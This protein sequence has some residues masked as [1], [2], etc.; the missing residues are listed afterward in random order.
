MSIGQLSFLE[1]IGMKDLKDDELPKTYKGIYAMHKYWSKKPYNLVADYIERFSSPGDI[2]LD[3]FCGSGVT[4]VESVR[5]GRRAIGIDINPVAIFI[6]RMGLSHIDIRDLRYTFA[7]LKM[8]MQPIIDQLY[9]TECLN[10]RNP[11]AIVTHTIWEE[12]NPKEVWYRCP[13]CRTRKAIK[14]A[15]QKD[16]KAAL[17]PTNT[18]QWAP[19]TQLVENSRVNVKAGMHVSDLFTKRALVG[20]SLLL[21]RIEQVQ[22]Q[23]IKS[24]L[25]FCFT[26]ALPQASNMVFVIRRR[27]KQGGEQKAGKAEVGS[28]VIGY[29]VPSEHFEINV[30][31]CFE[32]RFKRILRGKRE[33]NQV[34]P[35][36]A[37]QCSNFEQLDQVEQGYWIKTGT[38]TSL[39]IPS[40]TVGYVF[41][42]PPHGNR[43]PYL[44]LSLMWNSWLRFESNWE[45]EIVISAS[46]ERQKDE[47]DYRKRLAAAFG[48]IWRVLG[49]NRYASIVFNSLSDD[50]WLS[51]L[52]S[53]L[54]TGFEIVDIQPLDYS[55]HSVIQDTRKQAL[56]TDLVITCQKQIP[57]QARRIRFNGSELELERKLSDYLVHHPEGAETYQILN[58]LLVSSIPT[59]SIYR[60]SSILDTLE[61]KFKFA[62]GRW[63]LESKG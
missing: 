17:E 4:V 60:V 54:G 8:E 49:D 23:E 59:G 32:N 63:C 51:L 2:V 13:R 47:E 14:E 30:W 20:L 34:I 40:G 61:D 35:T 58:A 53:C 6:T 22:D 16:A 55:A 10:C 19:L 12:D 27:G 31:R 37:I 36:S 28:W 46:P 33:I 18:L 29:W 24:V 48:E 26:G 52:N 38:A 62:Q 5:L 39:K 43:M 41:V 44:E 45:E 50:T 42:D 56:K 3:S 7:N 11:N 9:H 57:K 15:S 1:N 21:E 25:K